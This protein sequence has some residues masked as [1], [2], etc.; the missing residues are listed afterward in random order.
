MILS[1]IGENCVFTCSRLFLF[2]LQPVH[3]QLHLQLHLQ[4]QQPPAA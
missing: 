4:L 2:A 1:R 3:V